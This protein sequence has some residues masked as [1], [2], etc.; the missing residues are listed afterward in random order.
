MSTHVDSTDIYWYT[1]K[2]LGTTLLTLKK[3]FF[4]CSF[5]YVFS[6]F[7]LL[8]IISLFTSVFQRVCVWFIIP[9]TFLE[10]MNALLLVEYLLTAGFCYHK[11]KGNT[12]L[13]ASLGSARFKSSGFSF[14]V[15]FD[16][17]Q[18]EVSDSIYLTFCTSLKKVLTIFS[19]I[20]SKWIKLFWN[21]RIS[22]C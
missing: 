5:I 22:Y 1:Q 2:T 19:C 12:R 3:Y 15:T 6:L 16:T 7:F 8:S 11:L 10:I 20:F 18:K 9:F 21:F 17:G 14:L 13:F 4:I